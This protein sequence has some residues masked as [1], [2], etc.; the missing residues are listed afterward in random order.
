[1][2]YA[3]NY[4][5]MIHFNR[6]ITDERFIRTNIVIINLCEI[7]IKHVEVPRACEL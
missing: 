4:L 5:S 6:K 3:I 2:E 7:K 1:M